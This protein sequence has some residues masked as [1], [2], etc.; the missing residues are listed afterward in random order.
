M[1]SDVTPRGKLDVAMTDFDASVGHLLV[2]SKALNHKKSACLSTYCLSYLADAQVLDEI[3]LD[4]GKRVPQLSHLLMDNL[5]CGMVL[6][7][8]IANV[9]FVAGV[10]LPL[11]FCPDKGPHHPRKTQFLG[12]PVAH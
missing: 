12:V 7:Q 9:T 1:K 8:K 2:P 4:H 3:R 11:P 5:L 6:V 10:F